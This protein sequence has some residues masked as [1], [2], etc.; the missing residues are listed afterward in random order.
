MV[1]GV[2]TAATVIAQI[3]PNMPRT[4]GDGIIHIDRFNA[5]VEVNDAIFE[6]APAE[7]GES[8]KQIGRYIAG[9]IEDGST[10]QTGIG[11][12]PNA[13]LSCL[14][15]HKDIGIHTEMLCAGVLPLI[16]KGIINGSRK[17]VLP[18]KVVAGFAMGT[19]ALYDFIHDNAEVLLMDISF[20]ND[21]SVI[22]RN[23][24]MVAINSAV[25]VD[26]T[27]QICADSIGSRIYSGVGGQ[28]DFM[29]GAALSQGGKAICALQSM[30]AKGESKIVSI[31]KPGAGVVTTRG[32]ARYVI[33][34]YGVAD[35]AG[36]NLAQRAK[37]LIGISHPTVRE[38]LERAAFERYGGSYYAF[39][40][41]AGL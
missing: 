30:T 21:T 4:M 10:L 2:E 6:K 8:E 24:K 28:M 18:R 25:E 27:G 19:R 33:T 3:N 7:P 41:H 5:C 29:R 1:A 16:E 40:R 31:L 39:N 26:L 34:E 36:K 37:A 35:L 32:H 15:N 11:A 22:R 9:L 17:V 20:V 23:P 13:A 14:Q 12:I 38:T